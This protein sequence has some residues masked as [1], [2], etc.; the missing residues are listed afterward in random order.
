MTGIELRK[1]LT[2]AEIA[3]T[4]PVIRELRQDLTL[5]D[6]ISL[7]AE[8]RR[9]DDYELVAAFEG[10]ACV[11]AMG[12]RVLFDLVH[13]KHLYVD[14]L[15]VTESHRSRGL[16]ARLLGHAEGEAQRRGCRSLRLCAG[17][18]NVGGRRFYERNGWFARSLV[19]KKKLVTTH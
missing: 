3:A 11:A 17:I 5:P 4:Y 10:A 13:G 15:V 19:F 1:A 6:F 16:G 9:R 12:Y 2:E 7:V 18:E 14:D 8:A